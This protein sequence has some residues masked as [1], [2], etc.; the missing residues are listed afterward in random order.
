MSNDLEKLTKKHREALEK[1]KS[2][3]ATKVRILTN[4]DC[5]PACQAMEG[6]Y[7]FDEA[8]ELPTEGC[9]HPN[10]CRCYYAPVLDRF[11]P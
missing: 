6:A 11:G 4:R 10:G 1:I 3:L 5:C 8:P 7:D 2:G 9:S